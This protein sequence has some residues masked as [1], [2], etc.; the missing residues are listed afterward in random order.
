MAFTR[1]HDD[2]ARI[3]KQMEMQTYIGRYQMDAPGNGMDLPYLQDPQIR[4]QRWG[5]NLR[6]NT[7]G[8][9]GDLFGLSRRYNRDLAEVNDYR[10]HAAASKSFSDNYA[11]EAPFVCESRAILPAWMLR[12]VEAPRWETPFINPQANV[13]KDFSDNISTRLLEK[14]YFVR[15]F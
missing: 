15:G 2:D 4:L 10:T 11:N 1:F 8:V 14:D 13:E 7:V 12:G 3:R 9:E 6:T 5:C